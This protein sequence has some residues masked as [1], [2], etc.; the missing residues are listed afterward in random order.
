MR[1]GRLNHKVI[2][3]QPV[4]VQDTTGQAVKSWTT[5]ASVWA[6]VEPLKGR[7]F[8][9]SQQINAETSTRVRIR[10]LAGVTQKMRISYDSRIYNINTIL[11]VNE[12]QREMHLMC[13]EGTNDG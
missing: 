4:E 9:E 11:H 10:K 7:E 3:Q 6:S 2:I 8:L 13:S 12:R 5:Y 1:A